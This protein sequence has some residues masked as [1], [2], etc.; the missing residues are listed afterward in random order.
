MLATCINQRPLVRKGDYVNVGQVIADAAGRPPLEDAGAQFTADVHPYEL[1]KL[2]L[3]NASHSAMGYLGYL[4][5][6]RLIPEVIAD[7]L[8]HSYIA[9]LMDDEVTPLLAPV[10]GIN[11]AEYKQT[12]LTRFANP[13]IANQVQRI[14]LDGSSKMPKFVLPSIQDA[15]AQGRPMSLLILAVA[16]WFRYLT[17][18]DEQDDPI[19]IKTRSPRNCSSGA[20]RRPRPAPP[21]R[22]AQ[23]LRRSGR[24]RRNLS[25][26]SVR[27][28]RRL[29]A[30]G[31]RETLNAPVRHSL[32]QARFRVKLRR[33]DFIRRSKTCQHSSTPRRMACVL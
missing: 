30:V 14:C 9:H 32:R 19:E 22:P 5:G 10:P 3:L 11:L 1:M 21:A 24:R 33:S 25:R 26:H 31:A 6:Y 15:L 20:S 4:A 29:Y 27:R 17:G 13:A 7:P 12:L 28:W 16:G 23:R 8:F 2:R 18:T